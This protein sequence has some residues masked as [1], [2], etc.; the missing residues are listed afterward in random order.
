MNYNIKKYFP[1]VLFV[2]AMLILHAIMGFNGDD[3]KYA[4]VLTN[5]SLVDYINYRYYNWSSRL[6]IDGLLVILTHIDMIIWKILDVIIY[7]FGVYYIIKLVNKK[8]SKKMAYF[9]ILL[10]LMYPF[11]EMASAG[12]IST[13]LNYSWCFAFGI[14]SFIPLI[15]EVQGEKVNRYMYV[16]SFLALLFATNQEQS[17]ALIFAFNLL[18]LLNSLINKKPINK[19]NVLATVIS[20]GALIFV[21][22]CPGN[23][24][25]FAHEVAYWYPEFANFTILDKS[26]LGLV[27]TFGS[28]IEQK[29]LFPMFYII[30]SVFVLIRSENKYLKYF[31]YFNIIL[32]VFITVFNTFIDISIL[33]TSLKSLGNVP[34]VIKN[35]PLM[36]IPHMFEQIVNATPYLT[37]TLKL[38]TYEGLPK[39]SINSIS[40]VV[41]C[42]YLLISS[43]IMLVKAFP[44]NLLP[45]FIFLGGF[46]S[47]FIVGFS[48]VVF[49]SGARVTIFLYV[50]LITLILML[51][52][53]LYDNNAIPSRT[54]V[55]LEN[56]FLIIAFLNYV[57]VFAISFMK[58][59]I[60]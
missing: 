54:Q 59:G 20:A 16:I 1:F 42:L 44:K 26:Y 50:A 17:G 2:G 8:Y 41:L 7:T 14:I 19:F 30:L 57:I 4:K 24:I 29:I 36:A 5:Q 6:I 21:F 15:Y 37:E 38:F 53:K 48:P 9:G 22:T 47:R 33:E 31:C 11:Y 39:L 28:L 40:I 56:S 13:T 10:F 34:G 12:W 60:F 43:C 49:P 52:K 55:I 27:T 25:R 45:F 35:S 18:Y 58:Y 32:V 46:V 3:I 51:L 23:T